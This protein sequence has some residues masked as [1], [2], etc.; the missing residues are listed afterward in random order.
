MRKRPPP[1]HEDYERWESTPWEMM[2]YAQTS[3]RQI[4]GKERARWTVRAAKLARNYAAAEDLLQAALLKAHTYL[5]T[6][7][8]GKFEAWFSS[9][10]STVAIDYGR[11]DANDRVHLVYAREDQ[12]E[13]AF[14]GEAGKPDD[15]QTVLENELADSPGD[16][17]EEALAS[18][19]PNFRAAVEAVDVEGLPYSE[20]AT[21]LGVPQGTLMSRLKRGRDLLAE[22]LEDFARTVYR[23]QRQ[24]GMLRRGG[25][26]QG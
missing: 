3:L 5:D 14:L 22:E 9:V 12:T 19:N 8:E 13:D 2:D 16:I 11:R 10:L 7:R 25:K 15:T 18:L 20:A 24:P 4:A 21:K 6:F 26:K 17:V 1:T 23:I